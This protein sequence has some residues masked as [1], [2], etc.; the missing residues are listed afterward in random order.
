MLVGL[1]FAGFSVLLRCQHAWRDD[2][3]LCGHELQGLHIENSSDPVRLTFCC[4]C[5]QK[6]HSLV[7]INNELN[8][9]S[10]Q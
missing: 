4:W 6:I 2:V 1:F 7:L 8:G 10:A 5:F 9:T 3:W